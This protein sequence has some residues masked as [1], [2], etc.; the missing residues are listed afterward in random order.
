MKIV[1]IR[2]SLIGKAY[3]AVVVILDEGLQYKGGVEDVGDPDTAVHRALA[4]A[5]KKVTDK[6]HSS[7]ATRVT[8][9]F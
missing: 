1:D 8:V 6:L 7:I 9:T 4:E 2:V 5:T 3:A